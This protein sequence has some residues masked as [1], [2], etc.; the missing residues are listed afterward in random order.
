MRNIKARTLWIL[1]VVELLLSVGLIFACIYT[2]DILNKVMIITMTVMFVLLTITIQAASFKSFRYRPKKNYIVKKYVNSNDLYGKLVDLNFDLRERAYGK[3]YI[4]IEGKSAYK[5]VLISDPNGYFHHEDEPESNQDDK[6]GEKLDKCNTFTAIEIFLN[7]N[8]E[9]KEK[10]SDFTIQVEKIYYTAFEKADDDTF[11]C[12]NYEK[13]NDKH[14]DDYNHLL[15]I[16]GFSEKI[17]EKEA[18]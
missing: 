1:A 8:S 17:E 18:N 6:L 15:D 14:K 4:K 5:V 3:S 13:P 11:I 9:V 16:L 2:K 10:I 12:Y 7:T